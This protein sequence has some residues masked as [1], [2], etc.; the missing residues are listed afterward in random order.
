MSKSVWRSVRNH[1]QVGCAAFVAAAVMLMASPVRATAGAGARVVNGDFETDEARQPELRS[2]SLPGTPSAVG[3]ARTGGITWPD[4]QALPTFSRPHHLQVVDILSAPGDEQMLFATLQGVVNR[5]RPR[6]Y[7]IQDSSEDKKG[8]FWLRHLDVPYTV[9]ASPWSL[10]D[11]FGAKVRG[12]IVYDPAVPD[13]INL[14][15]TLAGLRRGV[16]ATPKLADR[17][18]ADY[19][20]PVLRDL[21]GRFTDAMDAYTWQYEYLWSQ[22][23]HR[24]LI[25]IPPQNDGESFGMLRD[26]AV[27]N[28]AMVFWLDPTDAVERA[29]F[30]RILGDVEPNTPYL[31]WFAQ[32]V[33]GESSGTQL[34]SEH[35]VYVLAAD[36][37][38]NM[39]VFS[40]RCCRQMT[41]PEA[42]PT[43]PLEDRIF[44]TFTF[45]DGDN[46]Q[47]DQQSMRG[48]WDSPDR[49]RVPMNWTISPLLW[50]AAPAILRY[51]RETATANDLLVAGASGAGY[52]SPTPWPDATLHLFT[53]QTAK[54]MDR[55]GID[56]VHVLNWV[57]GQLVEMSQAEAQAYIDDVGP[58]GIMLNWGPGT[59]TT[60]LNGTTPQSTM[61]A[62]G[63]VAEAQGA[64]A[65]LA[66]GW[67]GTSPLFL[68]I[69]INAWEMSPSDVV[70][71][72]NSLGPEYT[73][74]RADQY[75]ELVREA[76]PLPN[77]ALGKPATVSQFLPESPPSMAVDGAFD[78]IWN[79]GDYAP[80]WIEIDLGSP[81]PIGQISLLTAQLPRG[82][83]VHR[84]LGKAGA[85]D[86]YQLLY[87]F[88]G[89]TTDGQWLDYSPPTPWEDVRFLRVETTTSPSWVAW[90]EIRVY[91]PS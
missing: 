83:T 4:G 60:I 76:N 1:G 87:E 73:V 16:V 90:R 21:R 6:I 12:T 66:A 14:A 46:L 50:D 67:D 70:E 59:E 22:T 25:G 51:Y 85:G 91:G 69:G 5:Q 47:Y 78:F 26:Y 79:S 80:Q 7:L 89:F 42:P 37:F 2:I 53:E 36:W 30:E 68:S 29:L 24:M 71:I 38:K 55:A 32:D 27:A 15:T 82:D 65:Q 23:T 19:G 45:S 35:G 72:A 3:A 63:S 13:T 41:D 84:V 77:L 10:L 44:V 86:P 61:R 11:R 52:A 56:T 34:A 58:V 88:T 43:P 75:F 31:G 64:I 9:H 49:G 54:Y 81:Q 40:A 17:L 48:I 74:V 20:L 33:A 28:R 39:T 18:E 8:T 57:D 62:T